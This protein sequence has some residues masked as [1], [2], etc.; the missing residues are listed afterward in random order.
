VTCR[1]KRRP[2]VVHRTGEGKTR[3]VRMTDTAGF[4]GHW[5]GEQ[6]AGIPANCWRMRTIVAV[7]VTI[8]GGE[9]NTRVIG[10][11]PTRRRGVATRT[12]CRRCRV[13]GHRRRL[14]CASGPA[15]TCAGIAMAV[16]AYRCTRVAH[17]PARTLT[18]KGGVGR[19]A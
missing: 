13:T 3:E 15:I 8:G 14:R 6:V 5:C 16:G 7:S 11:S 9:Y 18:G 12:L 19:M 1:T 2:G 4:V 17:R 10:G